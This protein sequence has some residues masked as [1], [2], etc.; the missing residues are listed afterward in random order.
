M[1]KPSDATFMRDRV[2]SYPE[3]ATSAA[4]LLG[5]IGTGNFSVGS[6]GQFRDWEIF[7]WPGKNNYLPFSFFAIRTRSADGTVHTAAL[8]AELPGP[9]NRSHGYYN[10]ELAGLP[11]F[12]HSRM[13]SVYPFVYVELTDPDLPVR[14]VLEAFTPFVPLDEVDSGIPGAIL[15]YHVTNLTGEPLEVS[16]VGSFANAI[17]F[18]GYDVFGNLKLSGEVAN[19]LRE[20]AAGKGLFYT[21]DDAPETEAYGSMAFVTTEPDA[22]FRPVWLQGQWTDNAQDFWDD[23][24]DDGR[25]D[26]Y[27]AVES[28]G[29]E[30][31]NFYDFSYLRLREKIG[32]I[33]VPK[34]L[35][36]HGSRSYEFAFAWHIPN[37]PKGWVEVDDDL[38]RHARGEYPLIR[39]HYATVYDDAWA[40]VQD[41]VGRLPELEGRSR[42][43]SQA[44]YDSSLP[45]PVI[46]AVAS[47]LTVIR[48]STCF[49][50]ET[51]DF[52]GWEG[53]RD[54]VGCGLG[55]VNHVWNY[56]QGVAFLFPRLERSMRRAEFLIELDD[57]GALPFRSRQTLGEPR[58]QMVPAADGHL[59]SIVR[60]CREWRISGDDDFLREIWPAVKKAMAYA[61]GHWDTD[62]DLVPDSQQ[63]NTYDIEFYGPN[64]MTGTFMVA[65]L[66][67]GEAMA[68]AVGEGELAAEYAA[69]AEQS[70]A[71]LDR[72]CWNGSYFEQRLEDVD[73]HRYQFGR[74]CHSDQLL[75]QFVA[76]VTG[77]GH[78][79]PSDHIRSALMSIVEHN[80]V[81]RMR[82][83]PTVQ[84]VY[85]LG[86]EPGLVLCSWPN[87]GRPRFPFG[88]SDEVWTGVEHQV[89]SSLIY[90]GF[91]KEGVAI[92]ER[93]RARQDG[94]LR[95]PWSENEAGHHYTRSLASYAL[96]TAFSGFSVDLSRGL[97]RFDPR[98]A[99]DGDF[100]S[101][102]CHGKGWGTYEQHRDAD[103]ELVARIEVI[104]GVL[105]TEEPVTAA[106]RVEIV[107]A[108][109]AAVP[110][111]E[112]R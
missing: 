72:L 97:V 102:W 68:T 92:V 84:R 106:T 95:N 31:D 101:F 17:G 65:A 57:D 112:A 30:L 13:W 6:R 55:N 62:G 25:L 79:L 74:G 80:T 26:E 77:L 33:A 94:Y 75:G 47:N 78:L 66:R 38:A 64:G 71:N 107:T 60:A 50:T 44:L 23:F 70:A 104:E 19:E 98:A 20:G 1:R 28:T 46:D 81:R 4:F 14:A 11:R 2:R 59:G 16:V 105:G 35:P 15:R 76:T 56:A 49:W 41:L 7:N 27:H 37:R 87:G 40:V 10:G 54:H 36:A 22:T 88:Y 24:T 5:G 89:A 110:S 48:S 45:E 100:R 52:Y 42:R 51:G 73:A 90:E 34:T 85:A 12:R 99:E 32:S 83:V 96:L 29:S 69:Q 9:H 109:S 8:E 86:D 111:G 108:P 103:G 18:E 39:N 67:A 93:L 53:T 91:V 63:S 43:F 21:S 3:S 61:V 82:E 58:W